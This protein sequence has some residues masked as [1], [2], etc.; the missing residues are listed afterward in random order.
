MTH[1]ML[2]TSDTI[3]SPTVPLQCW[4]DVA[5]V[6]V[7]VESDVDVARCAIEHLKRIALLARGR[8]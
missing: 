8:L 2:L 1:F 6:A 7:D 3:D 4:E 5:P